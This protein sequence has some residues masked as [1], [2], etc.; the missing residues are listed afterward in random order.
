MSILFT[1]YFSFLNYLIYFKPKKEAPPPKQWSEVEKQSLIRGI[2]KYGVGHWQPMREELLQDWV[3]VKFQF[4]KKA[5]TVL[6]LKTSQLLGRQSL[7]LYKGWKGNE[8]DIKRERDKNR[9][10]GAKFPGCWKNNMLVNDEEG[11]VVQAILDY[12]KK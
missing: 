5:A 2:E 3:S 12:D 4:I 7:E 9:E 10:I 6:R 11:K 1:L 8:K